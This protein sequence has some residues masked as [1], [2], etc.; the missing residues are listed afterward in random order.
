MRT[1]SVGLSLV[2]LSFSQNIFAAEVAKREIKILGKVLSVSQTLEGGEDVV[3]DD[4]AQSKVESTSQVNLFGKKIEIVKSSVQYRVNESEGISYNNQFYVR[5][6]KILGESLVNGDGSF[7]YVADVPYTEI[8]GEV[9]SYSIGILSLGVH[10]GL[11]FDGLLKAQVS[12]ELLRQQ[13]NYTADMNLVTAGAEAELLAKGYAEGQVKV[14]FIKGAIG[15]AVNLIDGKAGA[16]VAVNPMTVSNPTVSYQGVVH[17]LSGSIYGY[18]G[19]GSSRWLSYDFY[20]H[21]GLCYAFGSGS[22]QI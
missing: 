21:K 19:S 1:L 13:P 17:L 3:P 15:G 4:V 9:L 22:C 2:V 10:T 20:K 11:S 5:G 16:S 8:S 6:K 14:F 7:A 18:V 12:S